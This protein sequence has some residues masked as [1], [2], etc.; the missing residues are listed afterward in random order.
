MYMVQCLD[1]DLKNL[2]ARCGAFLRTDFQKITAKSK[3]L[4]LSTS[5]DS[6]TAFSTSS[7][8]I[9]L[10]AKFS[11]GAFPNQNSL[12]VQKHLGGLGETV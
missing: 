9:C 8:C 7:L 3:V 10:R 2:K 5:L 1:R 12:H 11:N 6:L 4:P